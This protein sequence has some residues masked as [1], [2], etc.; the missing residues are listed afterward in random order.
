MCVNST[1]I[2]A[3]EPRPSLQ[4]YRNDLSLWYE[5]A[6]GHQTLPLMSHSPKT[7]NI[8]LFGGNTGVLKH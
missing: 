4:R 6:V 2:H 1:K 3:L 7:P 5:D 8:K